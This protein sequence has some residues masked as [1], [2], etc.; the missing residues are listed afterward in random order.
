MSLAQV[1]D[2]LNFASDKEAENK[3]NAMIHI[4]KST[5]VAEWKAKVEA[6]LN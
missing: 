3:M 5:H 2:L 4:L 1:C 6:A